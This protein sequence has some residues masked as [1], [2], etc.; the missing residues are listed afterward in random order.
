MNQVVR[1]DNVYFLPAAPPA[2]VAITPEPALWRRLRARCKG[3]LWRVR[4]AFAGFRMALR[5]PH[6]PLFADEAMATLAEQRAELIE[7][8]PRLAPARIIDFG[9]AR[10]RLRPVSATR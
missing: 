6:A 1:A 8:R 4:F 7:R 9:S 5:Q 10:A 3:E 2:A